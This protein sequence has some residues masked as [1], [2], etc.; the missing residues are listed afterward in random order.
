MTFSQSELRRRD[1]I[2]GAGSGW[3]L[4]I[5]NRP[6]AIRRP[7]CNSKLTWCGEEP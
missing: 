1:K 2:K 3:S 5:R 7:G 6:L 4:A